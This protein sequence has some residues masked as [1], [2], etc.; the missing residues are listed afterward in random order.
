MGGNIRLI[1]FVEQAGFEGFSVFSHAAGTL[2]VISWHNG[3]NRADLGA[4][5]AVIAFEGDD[6]GETDFDSLDRAY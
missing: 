1:D 4:L 2:L 5:A 3:I 6:I